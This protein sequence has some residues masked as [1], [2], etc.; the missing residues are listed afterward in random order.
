LEPHRLG[1]VHLG[2]GFSPSTRAV[3]SNSFPSTAQKCA[4]LVSPLCLRPTLQRAMLP[5]AQPRVLCPPGSSPAPSVVFTLPGES[6]F[7]VSLVG[8]LGVL[9]LSLLYAALFTPG[10]RNGYI[11][12]LGLDEV[13]FTRPAQQQRTE[14]WFDVGINLRPC[15]RGIR[16][17][18]DGR[19]PNPIKLVRVTKVDPD[20]R[21]TRVVDGEFIARVARRKCREKGD[22]QKSLDTL[23]ACLHL[24]TS[25]SGV[26]CAMWA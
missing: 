26:P 22:Y 1:K 24:S 13:T 25:A 11:R 9:V 20:W 21:V 10:F 19:Y 6:L 15:V 12:C 8:S 23:H 3:S 16:F 18:R 14:R 2:R 17:E 7:A 4:L 5:K